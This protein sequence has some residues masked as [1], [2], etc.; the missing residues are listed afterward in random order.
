M[1][2]KIVFIMMVFIFLATIS[3]CGCSKDKEP[4]FKEGKTQ[5]ELIAER[6]KEALAPLDNAADIDME[7]PPDDEG[8]RTLIALM[9]MI[10]KG[11]TIE[12]LR[13]KV[14][15]VIIEG[16]IVDIKP[17]E[18]PNE[19]FK[20]L[21]KDVPAGGFS[22]IQ[23]IEGLGFG[24]LYIINVNEDDG[25]IDVGVIAVP[26]GTSLTMKEATTETESDDTEPITSAVL[27]G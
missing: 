26:P 19:R 20:A 25:L 10:D 6:V 16:P 8:Y 21:V 7:N 22:K 15:G 11:D 12:G 3:Y 13:E 4:V 18:M 5:E 24:V 17:A 14:E 23:E 1:R 27:G 9:D 2:G